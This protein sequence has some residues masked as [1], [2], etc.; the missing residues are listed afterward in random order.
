MC[1][2]LAGSA[3]WAANFGQKKMPR[4]VEATLERIFERTSSPTDAM[5]ASLWDLHRLPKRRALDWF[6][7]RRRERA[8]QRR[9][10]Q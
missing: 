7:Q 8:A 3:P 1:C 9:A 4:S 5:V 2:T 6:A 10:G